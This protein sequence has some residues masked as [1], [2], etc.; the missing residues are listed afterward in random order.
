[1]ETLD[2]HGIHHHEVDRLVENFIFL[3][4]TPVRIIVGNSVRMQEITIAVL[5]RNNFHYENENF[6][7]LGSF[8]VN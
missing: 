8:I 6:L 5:N 7:N 2:L 4:P 3:N 1:M